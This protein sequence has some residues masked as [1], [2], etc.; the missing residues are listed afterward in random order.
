FR[1]R[2]FAVLAIVAA[3]ACAQVTPDVVVEK[4]EVKTTTAAP[5]AVEKRHSVPILHIEIVDDET[6]AEPVVEDQDT[7][8]TV[9][10]RQVEGETDVEPVDVRK[11]RYAGD[12]H[13]Y[14]ECSCNS[15]HD[16][17]P[18]FKK[19]HQHCSFPVRP[20]HTPCCPHHPHPHPPCD[21]CGHNHGH[22]VP[23]HSSVF[24]HHHHHVVPTPVHHVHHD[25]HHHFVPK[26]PHYRKPCHRFD[27]HNHEHHY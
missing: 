16:H 24:H 14:P 11:K 4:R 7:D 23:C 20:P 26:R 27:H 6:N 10:K 19:L 25:V 15:K 21:K 9:Q 13:P 1:M 12:D 2:T 3:V 22:G 17:L 18:L 5:H 8:K